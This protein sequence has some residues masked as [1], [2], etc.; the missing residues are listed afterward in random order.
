MLN[1]NLVRAGCTLSSMPETE[2]AR[3]PMPEEELLATRK[4]LKTV[5]VSSRVVPAIGKY[6]GAAAEVG[7]ELIEIVELGPIAFLSSAFP[8]TFPC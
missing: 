3:Y 8:L 2:E 6:I 7:L 1:A 4:T 5:Q